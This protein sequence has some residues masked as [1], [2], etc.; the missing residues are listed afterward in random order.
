MSNTP[1]Q[2][3]KQK[4]KRNYKKK[5][6][7]VWDYNPPVHFYERLVPKTDAELSNIAREL[8]AWAQLDTSLVWSE[9]CNRRIPPIRITDL[10]KFAERS[11]D[12]KAAIELAKQM[13][14]GRR[15]AGA[16]NYKYNFAAIRETQPLY[17]P[18]YKDW[19]LQAIKSTASQ[20]EKIVVL[21]AIPNPEDT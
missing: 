13:L 1:T 21:P 11:E 18:E 12:L 4:K 9:F 19:K 17:D 14:A 8:I 5:E 20:I 15:E 16:I 2:E 6:L 3:L 10:Y 7:V